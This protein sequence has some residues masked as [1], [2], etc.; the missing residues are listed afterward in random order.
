VTTQQSDDPTLYAHVL[1]RIAQAR[2]RLAGL[3]AASEVKAAVERRLDR[4]ARYAQH[5]LTL[6]SRQ[7]ES[8][9]ADLDAGR[10]PLYG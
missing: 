6:A 10:A 5:D 1:K 3:D 2:E 4:L 9:H 7:V 8:V